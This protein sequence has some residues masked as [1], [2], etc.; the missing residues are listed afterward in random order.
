MLTI[1]GVE[2][3]RSHTYKCSNR[4]WMVMDV[5]ES[6]TDYI[7]AVLPL[8]VP[9]GVW[10]L[11]SAIIFKMSRTPL[12]TPHPFKYPLTNSINGDIK[13]VHSGNLS[14]HNFQLEL[15]I[16]TALTQQ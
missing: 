9:T 11:G 8:D 10:T 1:K 13:F 12:D 6:N 2:K 5:E 4:E 15:I 14:L 3:L 16:Q 7:F